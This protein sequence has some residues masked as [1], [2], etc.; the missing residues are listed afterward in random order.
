MVNPADIA[1]AGTRYNFHS[2]TQWCDGRAPID[3][4]T[5]AA[6]DAGMEH[7]GFSPHSPVPIVSS[8]NMSRESVAEYLSEVKRLQQLHAGEISLYTSME[9]DYLGTDWSPAIDYFQELPLD[10]RIG[11]VH[12]VESP[13]DGMVDID[14][15]P[16]RFIEKMHANFDD[17]IRGVVEKF[18][19]Q[20]CR[21]VEE[22]GFDI[23]GHFDKI[24]HNAGIF[25]PGIDN[26]PWYKALLD[27]LISLIISSGITVEINTKSYEQYGVMFPDERLLPRLINAGVPIVV[28][29]D[30]H[31]PDKVNASRDIG[32]AIL[33]NARETLK[34]QQ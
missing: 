8:C 31:Y 10:Y 34:K 1:R 13:R 22:G 6:I 14:G 33:A 30:A 29:S 12:F 21:M 11:S 27:N 16:E 5:R 18:F 3:V 28:N 2:H 4:M 20:S 19:T 26:E 7:W 17:D 23:I 9:I 25:S 24:R 15:R 32:L